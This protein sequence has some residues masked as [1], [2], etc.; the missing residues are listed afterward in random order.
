MKTAAQLATRLNFQSKFY[1]YVNKHQMFLVTYDIAV[2]LL[3]GNSQQGPAVLNIFLGQIVFSK[4][5]FKHDVV[6]QKYV[7]SR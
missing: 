7:R 4:Q 5:L 1:M 2:W 3:N 6:Y